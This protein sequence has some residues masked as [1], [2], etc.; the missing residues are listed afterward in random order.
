MPPEEGYKRV[1]EI[2]RKNFCRNHVV[3]Q[4]FLNKVIA[5]PPIRVS[6]NEKLSQLT[7]D[8][9][10]CFLGSSHLG[11]GA[12]INSMDT[13]GNVVSWL[14]VHLRS[15]WAEKASQL[16]DNHVTPD[17][18]H[19]T[20]FVQSRAAIANTYFGQI[21]G[22]K[23]DM[24][25]NGGDKG[26]RNPSFLKENNTSLATYG[27]NEVKPPQADPGAESGSAPENNRSSQGTQDMQSGGYN[28]SG[29]GATNSSSRS[30]RIGLQVVPV[31]VSAPYGNHVIETYAFLD[32]GSNTDLGAD[33]T[34][35]EL[36][37]STVSG[38]QK[39]N[40]QQLS[41]DVVG[42]ATGK[43][44]RL[45]KVW[46]TDSLPGNS[47]QEAQLNCIHVDQA[48]GCK[49]DVKDFSALENLS[50]VNR[51]I[52]HQPE[53][54][55]QVSASSSSGEVGVSVIEDT[56]SGEEAVDVDNDGEPGEEAFLEEYTAEGLIEE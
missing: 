48:L 15:K 23:V 9:E 34:P 32:S 29:V 50:E 35:V 7:R 38:N 3:T 52:I 10:T 44:V 30:Y 6:E 16:Y 37:L 51:S 36:T 42:V 1:K 54:S 24:R 4:S 56:V 22:S 20:E 5:G 40:G 49:E 14:P 11:N 46:T 13:L 39:R 31:R 12:N 18:I 53:P 19:L 2:L 25:K 45:N 33:C 47:Y 28:V 43:G 21:I 41:L 8:M 17:L 26:R 27:Q 55:Q